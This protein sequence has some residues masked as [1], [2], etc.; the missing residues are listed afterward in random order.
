MTK[1]ERRE[2]DRK[3]YQENKEQTKAR[4]KAYRENHQDYCREW[5]QEHKEEIKEY[6]REYNSKYYQKYRY[7]ILIQQSI[8]GKEHRHEH[9]LASKRYS[10]TSRGK[11]CS[12]QG[13]RKRRARIRNVDFWTNEMTQRWWWMLDATEGYCPKCGNYHGVDKLTQDH[14]I[15]LAPNPGDPQGTHHI[16]NVQVLCFGCNSSKGNKMENV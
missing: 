13:A 10:Q 6:Q 15:P 8:Y 2:Y 1:E 11:E 16:G 5:R 14:I 12:R 9:N 7:K 3:R 4:T